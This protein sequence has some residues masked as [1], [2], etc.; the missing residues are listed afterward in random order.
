MEYL[1]IET[2][3]RTD[4]EQ[5]L[6]FKDLIKTF[7]PKAFLYVESTDIYYVKS[8]DEFLRYRMSSELDKSKRAELTFKN[9]HSEHNNIVRT[10]VNLRVDNNSA[11][12]VET[13]AEGL[14][15]KRSFEI[16][17]ACDIFYMDD[18]NLVYYSVRDEKDKYQHFIEIEVKEGYPESEEQAWDI[19]TKYEKMLEPFGITARN[20]LKKSLFEIYNVPESMEK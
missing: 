6:K 8:G 7:E 9:K 17:K 11:E 3:Y 19:I 13:F 20:R 12:N 4:A 15:Y 16:W 5:R 2:K 18:A 1:E 14:G 10:E